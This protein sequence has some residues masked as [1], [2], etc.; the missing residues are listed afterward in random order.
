MA[1]IEHSLPWSYFDGSTHEKT[2]SPFKSDNYFRNL[3]TLRRAMVLRLEP[4]V[5][6]KLESVA[7]VDK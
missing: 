2:V 1:S 6:D 7:Y 4:P 5:C 3:A